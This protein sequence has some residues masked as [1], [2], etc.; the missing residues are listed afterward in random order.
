MSQTSPLLGIY[1]N[2]HLAGAT[3]GL[4]LFRRA[5]R[6]HA[7]PARQ[8]LERLVAEVQQDRESLLALMRALDVPVQRYKVLGG[9]VAEKAGRVKPN[10]HL[11]SRSPLSDLVELEGLVLGVRGKAAGFRAL[12]TIAADEP[13]L[14]AAE[15]DRLVDRAD[16]QSVTLEELRLEAARRAFTTTADPTAQPRA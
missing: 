16:Q 7:A 12:R 5:A 3:A 10:G 8:E 9:W 4:E 14:D 2:D 11:W 15:L 1:L 13:R 6:S